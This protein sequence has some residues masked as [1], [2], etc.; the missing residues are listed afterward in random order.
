MSEIIST[1]LPTNARKATRREWFG[2]SVL[3]LPTL[4]VSID[5]TITYLALP[6]ISTALRPTSAELLWITDIYG[7][8][9]AGLLII[10][11]TLGDRIGLRKILLT[12][13]IA[14]AAASV[15]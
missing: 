15:L 5:M 7:F 11:G 9:E 4:L 6:A 14:F 3:V 13:S 8:L 10:M 12:G 2:L 1:A